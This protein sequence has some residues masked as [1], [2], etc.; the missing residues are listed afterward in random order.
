MRHNKFY[1]IG[2][3]LLC[4]LF[5]FHLVWGAVN[6]SLIDITRILLG[7][8][9]KNQD[10][11]WQ[12]RL[13]RALTALLVGAGL[14]VA[15]LLMQTF[16]QN[17]LA[18]PSVLG[19]SSGASLGVALLRLGGIG[20]TTTWITGSWIVALAA[21]LGASIVML[22]MLG[23]ASHVKSAYS[24]LLLGLMIGNFAYALISLLQYFSSPEAVMDFWRWSMG[25]VAGVTWEHLSV[26]GS[27]VLSLSLIHI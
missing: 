24:L 8:P 7:Y 9:S 3:L 2:M 22:L 16:F 14:A 20:I 15:G 21:M 6:I 10:I 25:S 5:I 26:L 23:V 27:L 4:A 18:E 19:L 12:I 11:I 1:S 13:P 17:P